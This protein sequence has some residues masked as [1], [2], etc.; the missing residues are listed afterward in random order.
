MELELAASQPPLLPNAIDLLEKQLNDI[1]MGLQPTRQ[2]YEA[3]EATVNFLND[4]V[5]NKLSG[6]SHLLVNHLFSFT[7]IGR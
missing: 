3:R 2:G 5:R 1:Y 6:S 7:L 4:L